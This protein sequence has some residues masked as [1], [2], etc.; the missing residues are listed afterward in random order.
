MANKSNTTNS[1]GILTVGNGTSTRIISIDIPEQCDEIRFQVALNA[2]KNVPCYSFD[3]FFNRD[4]YNSDN[5]GYTFLNKWTL[6]CTDGSGNA[7]LS[8]GTW[9]YSQEI[10]IRNPSSFGKSIYFT[11]REIGD[12]SGSFFVQWQIIGGC[13]TNG[14]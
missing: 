14:Y 9:T 12:A 7:F 2:T 3:D 8:D 10:V 11:H 6:P 13:A 4:R 5:N 1:T